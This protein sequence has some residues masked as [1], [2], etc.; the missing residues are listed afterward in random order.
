MP[1][2]LL[3]LLL[4]VTS[5]QSIVRGI[6]CGKLIHRKTMMIESDQ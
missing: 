2:G 5:K 1:M 3:A 6:S 4:Q